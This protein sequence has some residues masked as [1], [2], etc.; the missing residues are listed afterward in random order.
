MNLARWQQTR[1]KAQTGDRLYFSGRGFLARQIKRVTKG[2]MTHVSRIIL[3]SD[4]PDVVWIIHALYG[5]GI[6]FEPASDFLA[7]YNGLAWWVPMDHEWAREK[8]PSYQQALI[9]YAM[10]LI[11][12]DKYAYDRWGA[13]KKWIPFFEGDQK[14]RYCSELDTEVD[15]EIDLYPKHLS[16]DL[17]PTESYHREINLRDE[18][19]A[20]F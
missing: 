2:D 12:V 20:L 10:P 16:I 5:K 7:R 19:V 9:R 14:A 1:S 11:R 8:N 13:L 18:R 6:I 4:V 17:H 3:L 15:Q